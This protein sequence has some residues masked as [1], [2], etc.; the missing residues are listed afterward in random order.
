MLAFTFGKV[1]PRRHRSMDK[2]ILPASSDLS[3]GLTL[4]LIY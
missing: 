2:G 1:K 4:G 3:E